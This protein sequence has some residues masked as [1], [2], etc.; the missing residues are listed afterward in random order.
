MVD[1]TPES[2]LLLSDSRS[3]AWLLR[4]SQNCHRGG[5]DGYAIQQ[6]RLEAGRDN[7]TASDAKLI[8]F[9]NAVYQ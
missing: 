1:Y 6:R 2:N 9:C 5:G 3:E 7:F 8:K 4:Y